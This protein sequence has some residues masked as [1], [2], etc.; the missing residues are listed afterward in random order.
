MDNSALIALFAAFLLLL[1]L[2]GFLFLAYMTDLK[3]KIF[4]HRVE[5]TPGSF[6]RRNK[7]M[8]FYGDVKEEEFKEALMPESGL[9]AVFLK[10]D[11]GEDQPTF[12][13]RPF[14]DYVYAGNDGNSE[15]HFCRLDKAGNDQIPQDVW[16]GWIKHMTGQDIENTIY[17][18]SW[19]DAKREIDILKANQN[20]AKRSVD[21][22]ISDAMD[23]EHAD[24]QTDFY[25][26]L[27]DNFMSKKK[28]GSLFG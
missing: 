20:L 3:S 19:I 24:P 11:F 14:L 15:V 28:G 5:K 22:I 27:L 12:P 6:S 25:K 10:K 13:A 17:S 26:K 7:V 1:G 18:E 9:N 23:E 21:R 4:R 8:A 2:L 16:N